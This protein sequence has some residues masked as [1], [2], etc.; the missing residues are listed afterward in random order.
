ML[1]KLLAVFL[2]ILMLSLSFS[3]C[4][5][6]PTNV[7]VSAKAAMLASLDT[8]EILYSKNIDEKVYPA[9]IAKIMTILLILEHP[10][11]RPDARITMVDEVDR[12][13]TGTGSA[14][15]NLAVGEEFSALDLVYLILMTSCG[16]CAYLAAIVYGGSVE[17]FVKKM[18]SRAAELGLTGTHYSNPVGLHDEGTYTTVRDIYTLTSYA[19]K[20]ETFK[21]V[22]ESV[23]YKMPA[24]NKSGER[25]LSTT[26]FLQDPSTNYYYSYAH[27]VKTGF[28]DEAGRC[29]VSTASYNGYRYLC[30]VMKCPAN[31]GQRV[32]FIQSK[33]LFRWAFNNFSFKQVA[34]ANNPVCEIGVDLSPDTD[35]LPLYIKNGFISVLPNESDTSTIKIVPHL[36]Q[37][38]VDA[39]VKKGTVL[40]TA[41][42]VFAEKTLGTVDLVAGNDV[43]AS[44]FLAVVRSVKRVFT[45]NYMKIV[46][47]CIGVGVLLFIIAVIRLNSGRKNKRKVRYIPYRDD[48]HNK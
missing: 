4:A 33:E 20:N 15:S 29:L 39:P 42:I 1:K 35:Y 25:T 34:D 48:N 36:K 41:D 16:D 17:N 45:S 24:T 10:D 8:G 9:S 5:Y 7:D 18:N 44:K 26:N 37:D 3:V 14:V 22:C 47:V 40:G 28:T 38:T 19:L 31:L 43:R 46:Y 30:I 27:G 23:R 2:C 32:E 21:T 13:I 12:W 11:F 6:E